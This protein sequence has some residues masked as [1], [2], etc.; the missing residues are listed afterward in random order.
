[1]GTEWVDAEQQ[2]QIAEVDDIQCSCSATHTACH[3]AGTRGRRLIAIICSNT[4]GQIQAGKIRPGRN[5][6]TQRTTQYLGALSGEV[7]PS[8]CVVIIISTHL[9]VV[10]QA[11]L[12]GCQFDYR[13]AQ[14][15]VS[16]VYS[17]LIKYHLIR[18][19]EVSE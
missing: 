18:V 2:Q 15:D 4:R 11:R 19:A 16:S 7:T 10:G 12:H 8:P 6:A 3:A 5:Q 9:R 14:L 13:L 17:V 1:M